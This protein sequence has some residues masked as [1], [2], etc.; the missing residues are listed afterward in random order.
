MKG[1]TYEMTLIYIPLEFGSTWNCLPCNVQV[2]PKVTARVVLETQPSLVVAEVMLVDIVANSSRH[3][4]TLHQNIS[5]PFPFKTPHQIPMQNTQRTILIIQVTSHPAPV[6][7]VPSS[8]STSVSPNPT[9]PGQ[10][11][12]PRPPT[13][14]TSP[15]A[16][17]GSRSRRMFASGTM[18]TMKVSPVRRFGGG[19]RS[20]GMR[21]YGIFGRMDVL[22]ESKSPSPSFTYQICLSI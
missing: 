7:N 16:P 5:T 14:K 8:S 22:V 21:E 10:P 4:S 2:H 3:C 11:T 15:T 20:R 18:A 6:P 13:A 17:L 12:A 9:S 19:E 1:R